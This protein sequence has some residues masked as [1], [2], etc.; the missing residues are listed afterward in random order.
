VLRAVLALDGD[1]EI[2]RD[3]RREL[4]GPVLEETPVGRSIQLFLVDGTP[5]GLVIAS[6]HG[7]TGSVLVSTQSTFAK[8]LARPE[9]DRT[10]VYILFGPDPS[11]PL[12]MRAYIGEADSVL[13]IGSS[14]AL[15]TV[16]SGSLR[17][18]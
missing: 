17:G 7:W 11:D 10:G 6:I 9:V 12:S 14:K 5:S 15:E 1:V 2:Y 8:L 18:L 16:G 13:G 4:W 3:D